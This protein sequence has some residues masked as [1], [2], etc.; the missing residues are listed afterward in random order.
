[1]SDLT[2][3]LTRWN[4]AGLPRFRYVDGNAASWLEE[5]RLALLTRF[6]APLND[7]NQPDPAA[8][9]DWWKE[10]WRNPPTDQQGQQF[11]QQLLDD[12]E[13]RLL[14]QAPDGPG[15]LWVR[16]PARP[17]LETEWSARLREQYEA[18][19]GDLAWEAV[20]SFARGVHVLTE[21]L[22]AYANEGYLGTATQWENVRRLISMLD[23]RPAPPASASTVLALEAR[24]ASPGPAGLVAKGFQIK[25]SPADGGAPLIFESLEDLEVDAGLNALRP[26]NHDRNPALAQGSR[27]ELEGRV[28]GLK[29]GEPL[30]LEDER[31]GGLHAYLIQSVSEEETVTRVDVS[32]AVKC[33]I[34]KGYARIHATPRERLAPL[35]PVSKGAVVGKALQLTEA[36]NLQPG[37]VVWIS[38]GHQPVF[39]RVEQVRGR[40][41]LLDIPLGDLRVD[42][43]VVGRPIVLPVTDVGHREVLHDTKGGQDSTILA[44]RVAGDW[45]RLAG[46]W[47][48]DKRVSAGQDP[49]PLFQVISADHRPVGS[50]IG[51]EGQLD[52]NGG[53]TVLRLQWS[54]QAVFFNP[55]SLLA[56][57][58]GGGIWQADR[59]LEKVFQPAARGDHLGAAEEGRGR[60]H[61]RRGERL[62]PGLDTPRR[63]RGR[64]RR[65]HRAA[66]GGPERLARPRRRTVL[67]GRDARLHQVRALGPRRGLE[68]QRHGSHRHRGAAAARHPRRSQ[69]GPDGGGGA[70]RSAFR[71]HVRPGDRHR[72]GKPRKADSRPGAAGR[73]A[74]R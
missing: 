72:P 64:R 48:A 9:L 60:R 31:N 28:K 63:D 45:T 57:P 33:G 4:R 34:P 39:R 51:N 36:P 46:D 23:V 47:L 69:T 49:L 16:P 68:R 71:L 35:A 29:A 26:L 40:R 15:P 54:H 20:R 3:D 42:R 2:S 65:R 38:D 62:D 14:W 55:Q 19:R 17:E 43:T 6:L 10:V 41:L 11:L 13:Q 67:P 5:L 73:R 52:P 58:P 30:V 56:P 18:G 61:R 32:P 37:D 53:Y 1:M 59:F 8:S 74:L 27:L 24:L 12:T 21:H 50:V 44:I 22:D 7:P 25:Y 70:G 66:A